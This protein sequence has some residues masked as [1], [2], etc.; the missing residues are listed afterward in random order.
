MQLAVL[1]P[2]HP[3]DCFAQD[4]WRHETCLARSL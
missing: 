3:I 1:G 2:P 4:F